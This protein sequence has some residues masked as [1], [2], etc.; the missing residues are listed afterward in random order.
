M[1]GGAKGTS[2]MPLGILTMDKMEAEVGE[3]D[4][5]RDKYPPPSTTD[6]GADTRP[7]DLMILISTIP[8][9]PPFSFC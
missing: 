4:D 8:T 2:E 9:P 6:P 7:E 3:E 1:D 5:D